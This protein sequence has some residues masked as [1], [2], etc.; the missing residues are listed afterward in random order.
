MKELFTGNS[1]INQFIQVIPITLLVGLLYIIFRFLKLKKSNGDINYKKESLY[2]I[3]VCY[4]VGLFNLVLVPRNFWDIIWYNI[5]YNFNENPFAG[6]FDFSYNFIPTI[7]KIIIG[8]YTIDSWGKTMIVGNLLMF[9][10]MGILLSLCLKSISRKDMFK[11][12][13]LIPLAIEVIQLVVGRSFDIDDLV[14]NFLGIV[15]GYYIVELVK[16]L[17]CLINV[18]TL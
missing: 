4:I 5:F 2:L 18:K 7:Y 3:F 6:I 8:E 1:V 9:I 15:I 13:L 16:K 17:K 10:P 14:M 11:Y 12:A